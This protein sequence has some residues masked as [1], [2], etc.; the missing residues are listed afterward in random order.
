[1]SHATTWIG[2]AL[3]LA[4]S[5]L[6][7]APMTEPVAN[8]V[9]HPLFATDPARSAG[10]WKR[11]IEQHGESLAT[12]SLWLRG[13]AVLDGKLAGN[14]GID[15][16]GIKRDAQAFSPMFDWLRSK[17]GTGMANHASQRPSTASKHHADGS[18]TA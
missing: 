16:I 15:L 14:K 2:T 11:G 18:P 12:R 3:I 7:A 8:A 9:N 6:G 10:A 5:A 1:M 4:N 13:Y 17:P